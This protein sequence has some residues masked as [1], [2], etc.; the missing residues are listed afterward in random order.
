MNTAE[1]IPLLDTFRF[2]PAEREV[3]KKKEDL[4]PSQWAEKYRV[5]TKGAHMGR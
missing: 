4:T 3:F 2:Y 5:V 1:Q